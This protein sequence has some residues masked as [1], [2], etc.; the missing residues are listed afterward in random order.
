MRIVAAATHDAALWRCWEWWGE[1]RW[2]TCTKK[3]MFCEIQNH[4]AIELNGL[5]LSL[6]F[7]YNHPNLMAG[8]GCIVVS[9]GGEGHCTTSLHRALPNTTTFST[10]SITQ[11]FSSSWMTYLQICECE[12]SLTNILNTKL[13]WYVCMCMDAKFWLSWDLCLR[14]YSLR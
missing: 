13:H 8:I 1:E 7:P 6:T 11:F 5:R 10:L 3:R 2:T 14:K 9:K 12:G 4:S